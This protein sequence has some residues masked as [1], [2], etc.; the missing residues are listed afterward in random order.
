MST[1]EFET[2]AGARRVSSASALSSFSSSRRS[3]V[4]SLSDPDQ[5]HQDANKPAFQECIEIIDLVWKKSLPT[6]PMQER[7]NGGK[8]E[9]TKLLMKK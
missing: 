3:S 6:K 2:F 1:T 7:R 4:T 5:D 8:I 9:I